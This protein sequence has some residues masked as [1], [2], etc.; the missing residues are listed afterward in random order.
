MRGIKDR[1]EEQEEED[2]AEILK[3]LEGGEDGDDDDEP[4]AT[5]SVALSSVAAKPGEDGKEDIKVEK[6]RNW[7]AVNLT[8]R[9]SK[10]TFR[11]SFSNISF[12]NWL[13]W[14]IIRPKLETTKS[15]EGLPEVDIN[16]GNYGIAD[17]EEILGEFAPP[18][19]EKKEKDKKEKD[20][21]KDKKKKEDK[22][23]KDSKKKERAQA[24]H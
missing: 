4:E 1:D 21:D 13:W 12:T 20:K 9:D 22:K 16:D 11:G 6:D 23:E 15:K 19:T 14:R 3:M 7:S 17:I 8:F 5:D 2:D 10:L 24:E 18:L